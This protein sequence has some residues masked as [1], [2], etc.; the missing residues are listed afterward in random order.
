MEKIEKDC[1]NCAHQKLGGD[2]FLGV[3]RERGK[4]I[5]AWV[6][7]KGC[8]KFTTKFKVVVKAKQLS[9]L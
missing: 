3:C 6:I 2:S 5:P 4:E 9:L 8:S 7:D 1:W